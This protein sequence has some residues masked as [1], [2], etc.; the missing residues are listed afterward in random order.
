MGTPLNMSL[1]IE[2]LV[3][4]HLSLKNVSL[5]G[6]SQVLQV[7]IQL[8]PYVDTNNNIFFIFGQI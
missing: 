1:V 5:H 2:C 6:W 7:W 4:E 3:R 8:L